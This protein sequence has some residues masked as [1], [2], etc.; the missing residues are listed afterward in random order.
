MGFS[1]QEYITMT[2][3]LLFLEKIIF[4]LTVISKFHNSIYIVLNILYTSIVYFIGNNTVINFK[5]ESL[6]NLMAFL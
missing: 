2:L 4:N 1:R 5:I 3:Y 6:K